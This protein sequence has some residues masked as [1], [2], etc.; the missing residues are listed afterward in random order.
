MTIFNL[1]PDI[2]L[3]SLEYRGPL[4][5]VLR[6]VVDCRLI[7][8][9]FVSCSQLVLFAFLF[10]CAAGMG[11]SSWITTWEAKKC[12][13]GMA[14]KPLQEIFL[15]LKVTRCVR[16]FSIIIALV[17]FLPLIGNTVANNWKVKRR[18]PE[19]FRKLCKQVF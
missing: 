6:Y 18:G 12:Y 14:W 2:I 13:N 1:W 9:L 17:A 19:I 10:K 7:N 15:S 4:V 11:Q 16:H 3:F 5:F 8:Y